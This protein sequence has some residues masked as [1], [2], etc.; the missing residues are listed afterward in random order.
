[1]GG[2]GQRPLTPEEIRSYRREFQERLGDARA[3]RDYLEGAGVAPDE[4]EPVVE[5]LQAL[6]AERLY[7]DL[8]ELERL[9]N[10]LRE[11]LQRLEFRLRR[12]VEGDGLNVRFYRG[13]TRCPKASGVWSRVLPG[14][15][16][17]RRNLIGIL[18]RTSGRELS[19]RHRG[20]S[21]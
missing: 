20:G 9:Q 5:A 2:Y 8:P 6:T 16:A 15:V 1:M 4:L 3:L 7:G 17:R 12:E 13:Q 10:E 18:A 14:T 21:S 19:C 11:G